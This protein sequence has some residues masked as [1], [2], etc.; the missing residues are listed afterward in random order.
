MSFVT[1]HT[2]EAFIAK[3]VDSKKKKKLKKGQEKM[4]GWGEFISHLEL[5]SSLMKDMAFQLS[6]D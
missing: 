2:G 3:Q 6:A 5:C 1:L 4:L